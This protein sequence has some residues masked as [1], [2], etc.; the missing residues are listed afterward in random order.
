VV[1]KAIDSKG[2][3]VG[4]LS[5]RRRIVRI[6]LALPLT[7]LVACNG[8]LGISLPDSPASD[9]GV[10]GT[11]GNPGSPE[12]GSPNDASDATTGP[13]IDSG[14]GHPGDTGMPNNGNDTGVPSDANNNPSDGSDGSLPPKDDGG[15]ADGSSEGDGATDGGADGATCGPAVDLN[16]DSH[17]CGR[18]GRDCGGAACLSGSCRAFVVVP[19]Q[20]NTTDL[21]VDSTGI[22]WTSDAYGQTYYCPLGCAVVPVVIG[23]GEGTP[24]MIRLGGG[25]AYWEADN[26]PTA[27]G[28]YT[29]PQSKLGNNSETTFATAT[30]SVI[31]S[32]VVDSQDVIWTS[33]S[34]FRCP[35]G[36]CDGGGIPVLADTVLGMA[37][38]GTNLAWTS[39]GQI[40]KTCTKANC[41]QQ[42]LV[43]SGLSR[44]YEVALHGGYAYTIDL[45]PTNT[46]TG[47]IT[48]CSLSSA[49]CTAGTFAHG[50]TT[51]GSMA[52]D[53]TGVY[54]AGP[55]SADASDMNAAIYTCPLAGCPGGVPNVLV[56]GQVGAVS[57]IVLTEKL[58]Y[59]VRGTYA[60]EIAAVAKP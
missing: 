7:L 53:D 32:L 10:D 35:L 19:N 24:E 26:S 43:S 41:V 52:V 23:A 11:A 44:A 40:L 14:S 5:A 58:V 13:Q 17:N 50:L 8:V 28:L 25:S 34:T 30:T 39:S 29:A 4:V 42:D 16:S 38:D 56:N 22:Y 12:A 9:G 54:W 20:N 45:G 27:A 21:A 36:G 6:G 60:N 15:S 49:S 57:S 1:N 46:G 51:N 47:A 59:F 48:K 33:T 3:N 37:S 55:E 31:R 18:C 2:E